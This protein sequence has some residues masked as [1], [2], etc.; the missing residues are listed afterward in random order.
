[1]GD[2]LDQPISDHHSQFIYI[3]QW[4]HVQ[5]SF[6]ETRQSS[7]QSFNLFGKKEEKTTKTF[8]RGLSLLPKKVPKCSVDAD[9]KEGPKNAEMLVRWQCEKVGQ[10]I[11]LAN[12][13]GENKKKMLRKQRG[14]SALL[15][16]GIWDV[17]CCR[18]RDA[19]VQACLGLRIMLLMCR[20]I[21]KIIRPSIYPR[22]G[23]SRS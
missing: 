4:C 12:A 21:A 11:D 23:Y 14:Y 9:Y 13:E 15:L 16:F 20:V 7:S 8:K 1:M 17:P 5:E 22:D 2:R 19:Y 18:D 3:V 6:V 10:V